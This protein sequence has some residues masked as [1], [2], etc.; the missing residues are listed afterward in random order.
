MLTRKR[1]A[2]QVVAQIRHK[3]ATLHF[4][5]QPFGGQIP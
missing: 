2:H 3:T 5:M 1:S 4:M